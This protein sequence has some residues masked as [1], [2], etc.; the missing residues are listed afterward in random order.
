MMTNSRMPFC[1]LWEK[2]AMMSSQTMRSSGFAGQFPSIWHSPG[3]TRES[4]DLVLQHDYLGMGQ[5]PKVLGAM[6]ETAI[7]VWEPALEGKGTRRYT[8]PEPTILGV[9][10]SAKIADLHDKPRRW[11]FTS[12]YVSNPTVHFHDRRE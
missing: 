6:V 2:N 5:H 11:F 1:E 8:S 3:G 9:T 12:G 4:S 7:C 10:S